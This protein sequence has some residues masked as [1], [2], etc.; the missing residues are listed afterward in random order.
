MSALGAAQ[1]PANEY[2]HPILLL[3][4]AASPS[5]PPEPALSESLTVDSTSAGAAGRSRRQ[6]LKDDLTRRKYARWQE[7]RLTGD[8][9]VLGAEPSAS[10]S[11]LRPSQDSDGD[12]EGDGALAAISGQVRSHSSAK[13]S[14]EIDVLYE[15]QRGVFICGVPLYS[16][17][18]LLPIDPAPWSN[19][20]FHDSMVDITNA[21]PP[22]PS[23]EWLWKS[24]FVDMSA[25]VDDEGWEYSFAFSPYFSWHGAHVW[26]HSFVRRRRWLRKRV[27]RRQTGRPK[28]ASSQNRF[29]TMSG[30]SQ[31]RQDATQDVS[32]APCDDQAGKDSENSIQGIQDRDPLMATLKCASTDREKL[33][34]IFKILEKPADEVDVRYLID[35]MPVIMLSL[36]SQ[37]SRQEL[38]AHLIRAFMAAS[39]KANR[40]K[41]E[42]G[43]GGNDGNGSD[44]RTLDGFRT[45][46]RVAEEQIDNAESSTA[47][48]G[49]EDAENN[50]SAAR[51]A[52]PDAGVGHSTA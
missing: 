31:S 15:N 29:S 1:D 44:Q 39:N 25:D 13:D 8:R 32:G 24:W 20:L 41:E 30:L 9:G 22:D 11:H 35:H 36:A 27:Q 28:T 23:W 43:H 2:D 26:F 4:G 37:A 34:S 5:P 45:A 50:E 7:S 3:D 16:P 49:T 19:A 10:T 46:I 52:Q 6:K 33:E 42:Q 48:Q 47:V 51:P 17:R 38:L 40:Q 12:E 18:S 21:Q 14:Y